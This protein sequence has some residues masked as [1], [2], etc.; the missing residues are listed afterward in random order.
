[1]VMAKSFQKF[2][3]IRVMNSFD[4]QRLKGGRRLLDYKVGRLN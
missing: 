3:Y 2:I 4:Y 1:M